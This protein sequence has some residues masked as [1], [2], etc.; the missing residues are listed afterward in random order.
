MSDSKP[1]VEPEVSFQRNTL[2]EKEDDT[3]SGNIHPRLLTKEIMQPKLASSQKNYTTAEAVKDLEKAP[4]YH[5]TMSFFLRP[6]QNTNYK[7]VACW[8]LTVKHLFAILKLGDDQVV[9]LK[10]N[11]EVTR[12]PITRV[13]DIPESTIEFERDFAFG[14][15][16]DDKWVRF[17]I[18]MALSIPYHQLFKSQEYG[19]ISHI[20]KLNWYAK[21]ISLSHPRE[22]TLM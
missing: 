12:N 1:L 4:S 5:D 15:S 14:I 21:R 8:T 19:V 3:P 7:S 13:D 9:F 20:Q 11:K 18:M 2:G 6:R 17:R 22:T 10:K 16:E